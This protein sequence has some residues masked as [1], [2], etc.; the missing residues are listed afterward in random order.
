MPNSLE[1]PVAGSS[2]VAP[3]ERRVHP[4]Y[5]L[6]A[7]AEIVESISRTKM[8]ARVSDLSRSGCYVEMMSPFPVGSQLKMRVMKNKTPFLAQATVAY[9]AE[10]MGMGV[11]FKELEPAQILILEKWLSELSGASPPED[12]SS[13]ES[14]ETVGETSRNESSYVLNEVI[15]ALMRKGILTDGEGKAMLQKLAH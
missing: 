14:L 1:K 3:E 10:G 7:D 15:I 6:S 4:R 13:E 2:S 11:K 12:E 5:S 8:S 9:A